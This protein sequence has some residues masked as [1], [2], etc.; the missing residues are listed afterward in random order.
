MKK[1][2]VILL[3]LALLIPCLAGVNAQA[4][5]AKAPINLYNTAG[6]EGIPQ[7]TVT[8]TDGTATI[9]YGDKTGDD[10]A[11]A[12]KESA[13]GY[14]L[15][16][17][18][19]ALLAAAE[20]VVFFDKAVAPMKTAFE[21]FFAYFK[22]IGGHLDGVVTRQTI[23]E[24]TDGRSPSHRSLSNY[25]YNGGLRNTAVYRQITENPLYATTIRPMLEE[26]GFLFQADNAVDPNKAEIFY[27][28]P[29]LER[30]ERYDHC[31]LIWDAVMENRIADHLNKA[32]YEPL[33]A[34]FPNA[35]MADFHSRDMAAW[36]KYADAYGELGYRGGNL[37]KAGNVSG[38]DT[39][40]ITHLY[41]KSL[42]ALND[43]SIETTPFFYA[44]WHTNRVADIYASTDSGKVYA[45][46]GEITADYDTETLYHLAL[47]G[48][49]AFFGTANAK[50]EAALEKLNEILGTADRKPVSLPVSWN[51]DFI[52]SGMEVGGKTYWRITPD[53]DLVSLEAFKVGE[54]T[55]AVNGQTVHFPNG[56]VQSDAIGYWVE[57]ENGTYP[58]ITCDADRYT[59]N[60][61]YI[62]TFDS[63]LNTNVWTQ[64]LPVKVE[65]GKLVATT[66]AKLQNKI[67]P[68][69]V[70]MD[71]NL[72]S[73]QRWQVTVAIPA[74]LNEDAELNLFV[75]GWN[76]TGIRITQNQIFHDVNGESKNLLNISFAK[77]GTY[78]L[79][80][81]VDFSVK[82]AFRS[83]Y[84]VYDGEG[85]LLAKAEDCVMPEITLPYASLTTSWTRVKTASV[86]LDDYQI[87]HIDHTTFFGL[88]DVNSGATL[89]GR[90][91]ADLGY[92]FAW[93]NATEK[94][95][96][97][98]IIAVH[99]DA[100]GNVVSEEILQSLTMTP[101]TDGAVSGIAE[102]KADSLLVYVKKYEDSYTLAINNTGRGAVG[103]GKHFAGETVRI[104][105]GNRAGFTFT[106]W[107]G[108]EGVVFAD[109]SKEETTFVMPHGDV[110][111][112]ATW[113]LTVVEGV[114]PF[115]MTNW[116]GVGKGVYSN[117]S[118][119]PQLYN[120]VID[121]EVV[122]A[123]K[124]QIDIKIIARL[125]KEEMDGRPAG[126]RW[127]NGGAFGNVLRTNNDDVMFMERGV[128][129]VKNWLDAFLAEYKAIGG[130]L[131]GIALD[132]EYF[133]AE[134]W[135]LNS[136]HYSKDKTVYQRIVTNP[137]YQTKLRPLLVERGF[138]F[139]PEPSEHTP[140]IYGIYPNSG[141]E[142]GTSRLVWDAASQCL[143]SMYQ[144]ES[145]APL[146]EHYP[147]AD[148][149]DYTIRDVR[150]WL[151]PV[152]EGGSPIYQGGNRDK[153]GTASS[154]NTYS[155]APTFIS[156]GNNG[157]T[158]R[159]P[160]GYNKAAYEDDPYNM[161]MWDV[162]SCKLMYDATPEKQVSM[163]FAAYCYSPDRPGSTS[164]TPYYA[165]AILHMG[166][167]NPEPFLGFI[168]AFHDFRMPTMD[169]YYESIQ[170]ASDILAELTR[171][172][173]AEDRKHI[174][175]PYTWNSG[176]ILTGMYA[177]GKNYWRI[178]PDTTDGMTVENFKISKDGADPTFHING[179]TVTFPGG[180][181]IED[182]YVAQVGTCGYWVETATD[183]MPKITYDTNRFEIAPS[184][185]ENYEGYSVGMKYNG[186]V[187]VPTMTWDARS[188]G[189][190]CVVTL[191]PANPDNQ[192]LAISG[193]TVLKNIAIPRNITA[194]D[195][196]A[197]EQMWEVKV[198]LPEDMGEA[199]LDLFTVATAYF[200]DDLGLQIKNGKVYYD[201]KGELTELAD[202]TLS[203]GT[204]T[205]KRMVNFRMTDGFVSSYYAYDAEGKQVF[206]V[207]KVP[208][209]T[210][211]LPVTTI[212]ITCKGVTGDP[213]LLDDY[214]LYP[215]GMT[216]QFEVYDASSGLMLADQNGTQSGDGAYRLSWLN[217]TD[218][219]EI[220]N[221]MAA[222][223]D[224]DGKLISK[225]I[226]KTVVMLPGADGIE[227]GIVENPIEG[228]TL[229]IYMEKPAVS[230]IPD[231][232]GMLTRIVTGLV[233]VA[234]ALAF[235]FWQKKKTQ[236]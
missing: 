28:N 121:G 162:N 72:A 34:S 206:A 66:G 114:R 232:G 64:S 188:V 113:E 68:P 107:K 19:E 7:L 201:C 211:E 225:K 174:P 83:S 93:L 226:I 37:S 180:K 18:Q 5:S 17:V 235:Y 231:N 133:D 175:F 230:D 45:H 139:W 184:F 65:D 215:V 205:F 90:Q 130:E 236:V 49:T 13:K 10:A 224:A 56:K 148:V 138:K 116:V 92:R 58:T 96:R 23:L 88:Y 50:A 131:D 78:I 228:Q 141:N 164:Y 31:R 140:E 153:M 128:E 91:Q 154:Y 196:Y 73:R 194:G 71:G 25:H 111:L 36:T 185:M 8:L 106:G 161:F 59:V 210:F 181:I 101:G 222:Y 42:Y 197:K 61:A 167:M 193:K 39:K 122:I 192:V 109:A 227:T 15:I 95:Q 207:E 63:P 182:G 221:V 52:L 67:Y 170:V 123:Y 48:V 160:V 51:Y 199:T 74:G 135:Y 169:E 32:V 157:Y 229:K 117:I 204:Y 189:G 127:I 120:Y 186:T 145:M 134:Y 213:I 46:I 168:V 156:A 203:A 190:S 29:K 20:D 173:G 104:N 165:E 105:A 209:L 179:Q 41:D 86:L 163:W 38:Y 102:K 76:D 103:I 85:Q 171:I 187:C 60:P 172:V 124:N 62:E 159:T 147:D 110:T 57:T 208:M 137:N 16:D 53:R 33:T 183:V 75:Y 4:A 26:R 77:G 220:A 6:E 98:D 212:G 1:S 69:R 82:G 118:G 2:I 12:L 108:S 218:K 223:Y 151:K 40:E 233:L 198:T 142:Y 24:L 119:M 22:E 81:E 234:V 27:I 176:Y 89:T 150:G 11:L 216:A 100:H 177:G 43:V 125:M 155:Y 9:H 129:I 14:V 143:L 158:Y 80:R 47:R 3:A 219:G 54:A 30:P 97:A 144:N 94:T 132:F 112:T 115:V 146:F 99:Y 214:K 166:L 136:W 202:V 44:K 217:G 200:D 191:D 195:S 87:C 21:S 178:T 149:N 70:T 79:T 55:F 84:F 35:N 152:D 126:T